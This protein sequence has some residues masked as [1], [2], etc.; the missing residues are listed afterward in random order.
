MPVE[1][2]I[3]RGYAC[4]QQ[5]FLQGRVSRYRRIGNNPD[6]TPWEQLTDTI[7]RISTTRIPDVLCEI[8]I[9]DKIYRER[10]NTA[11]YF[12]LETTWQSGDFPEVSSWLPVTIQCHVP[13]GYAM[14]ESLL[15]GE[16]LF[17]SHRQPFLVVS[18]IDDTLLITGVRSALYWKVLYNT[19]LRN[20]EQRRGI[21]GAP[22]FFQRLA[23]LRENPDWQSFVFYVSSTPR[24]LYD[25][26]IKWLE[27]HHFPQGPVLLKD[28]G[29]STLSAHSTRR[30]GSKYAWIRFLLTFF[31]TTTFVLVGDSGERDFYLYRRLAREHPGRVRAILIRKV[32]SLRRPEKLLDDIQELRKELPVCFFRYYKDA[33]IWVQKELVEKDLE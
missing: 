6:A 22:A 15:R 10:T 20:L 30:L 29:L 13:K 14:R 32:P 28:F 26:V 4:R 9:L 2:I 8:R 7:K 27:I 21:P 31:E 11:G 16:V 5:L 33:R 18:D 24:T 17:I 19:F 1:G 12:T 25:F 3:Y 23:R